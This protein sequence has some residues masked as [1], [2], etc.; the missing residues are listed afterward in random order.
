MIPHFLVIGAQKAGTTWLDR[1]LRMHPEIWLPPEKEMHYF[2][3][4]K[5]IPFPFFLLAPERGDRCWVVNRMKKAYHRAKANPDTVNWSLRYYLLPRTDQWYC[6]LFA[7]GEGQV[8]GEVTPHYAIMGERK[9]AGV[10]ALSPG[11]K[12]VYLLRDP[13]DRMWSHAAM[14][15]SARFGYHGIDVADEQAIVK[16][17]RSP[18]H[19][20]H[21]R[22][23]D[24]L[25]RWEKYYPPEQMFIGFF[26]E[27][28]RAPGQLL[29][30]IFQFLGITVSDDYIAEIAARKIFAGDYP[31]IPRHIA[32][33]LAA[34]L[35]D[36]LEK[37]HRRLSSPYTAQWLASAQRY[38]EN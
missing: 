14:H 35:I 38:L 36:D 29:T 2:D 6:S 7:P 22:Y 17:L 11:M 3:L 31:A 4:P 12:M 8:V 37:L 5:N 19:L 1:N 9:I 13:I 18:K 25:Q 30:A 34:S 16:F 32:G 20:A 27:I 15:F 10:H 21:A 23:F 26:D 33:P 28:A 24:N